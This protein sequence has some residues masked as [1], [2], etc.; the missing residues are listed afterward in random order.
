MVETARRRRFVLARLDPWWC[1]G[2]QSNSR[3]LIK[4]WLVDEQRSEQRGL[5]EDNNFPASKRGKRE[6]ERKR[7]RVGFSFF[8]RSKELHPVPRSS[9][10]TR[11]LS[12][13]NNLMIVILH[14][15][16]I[17]L[18]GAP[19]DKIFSYPY[20]GPADRESRK[21]SDFSPLPASKI[22]YFALSFS[23]RRKGV[24]YTRS[25]LASPPYI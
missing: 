20:S 10:I 23:G 16:V 2:G 5:N 14:Q 21:D 13:D 4:D 9:A 12:I 25:P 18:R 1:R 15:P 7:E 8:H 19:R 3:S 11:R 6:S 24:I 17:S 22:F